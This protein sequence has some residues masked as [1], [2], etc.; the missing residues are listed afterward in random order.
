MNRSGV[1]QIKSWV[2]DKIDQLIAL[3]YEKAVKS[4]NMEAISSR[5]L[6][7]REQYHNVGNI[8]FMFTDEDGYVRTKD[9]YYDLHDRDYYTQIRDGAPYYIS[10][11]IISRDALNP[12]RQP[13]EK[14]FALSVPNLSENGRFQGIIGMNF[15]VNYLRELVFQ[16]IGD[17]EGDA[18]IIDSEYQIVASTSDLL[19]AGNRLENIENS[20]LGLVSFLNND[21]S[22]TGQFT[23]EAR[24]RYVVFKER[25]G[26]NRWAFVSFIPYRWIVTQTLGRMIPSLISLIVLLISNVIIA[27]FIS[28]RVSKPVN[29][30]S[31]L[32]KEIGN[33]NYEISFPETND[34]EIGQMSTVLNETVVKLKENRSLHRLVQQH[35]EELEE[36][37]RSLQTNNKELEVLNAELEETY[38]TVELFSHKLKSLIDMI[39]RISESALN[40]RDDFLKEVLD[41]LVL[42]IP[43][44]DAASISRLDYEKDTWEFVGAIGFDIERLKRMSLKA[45]YFAPVKERAEIIDIATYD[46]NFLPDRNFVELCFTFENMK[47][48]LVSKLSIA[49]EQ[50]GGICLDL[51]HTN[52]ENFDNFDIQIAEAFSSIASSFLTLRKFVDQKSDFQKNLL[53]AM[54]KILE[55]HEP[56]T[57]GHSENVANLARFLA[58]ILKIPEKES[59]PLYWAGLVHDIGKILIP[60]GILTKPEKLE[61][62]EYEMIKKHPVWGAKFL[63]SSNELREL[64]PIIR[65]HHERWDGKGYP[66]GLNGENIP[67]F[68]RIIC[69]ADAFEAML[70]KRPYKRE[71]TFKEAFLEIERCCG[72]QF[73]P[74][75]GKAFLSHRKEIVEFFTSFSEDTSTVSSS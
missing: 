3:S 6:E 44:T 75:V 23:D 47:S 11:L 66:E 52:P 21:N 4:G 57:K 32:L 54:T 59:E 5:F 13:G 36:A 17:R 48:T 45:S 70:S 40:S 62:V 37:N 67:Y 63:S 72:T 27:F 10:D 7:L 69:L 73:D 61:P 65:Y 35:A 38:G 16:V 39:T 1:I 60:S 24:N 12:Y 34:D 29:T 71:M 15:P 43:K 19:G 50:V 31:S 9:Y 55:I 42:F 49:D 56:Y 46:R 8:D 2:N 33:D 20:L 41:L 74:A 51:L 22:E 28:Y 64:V 18:F 58:S 53:V 68:A 14:I 25:V 30:I 26:I